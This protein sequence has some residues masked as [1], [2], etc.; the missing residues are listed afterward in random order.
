MEAVHRVAA[1]CAVVLARGNPPRPA[2]LAAPDVAPPAAGSSLIA[3]L[4]EWREGVVVR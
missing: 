2:L 3:S 1:D 4:V